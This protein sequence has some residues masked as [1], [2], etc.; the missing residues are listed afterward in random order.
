MSLATSNRDGG[1]TNEAGHLRGVTKGFIGQVLSGLNVSQRG[2]GA[3]MSVDVAIGDALV[4]RSDN[5][6]GHPAWNDAAYNQVIAAADGSN[7]RRDIIVLYIDYG[8]T[9]ST[10]VAN[11]VN[12][13]VKI[14]SVAGTA[15]G[16]PVDPSNVTIQSAVGSGNPFIKLA[17]VRVAAGSTSVTNSVIDDLRLMATAQLQGGWVYDTLFSWVYAS[18]NSFTIAGVDAIS[19]FPVGARLAFYQAGTLKYFT[20]LSAA[21]STNTTITVDGGG[22]YVVANVPIDRPAFS[23]Q[24]S[25]SG[26][27]RSVLNDQLEGYTEIA[28]TTLTATAT[29]LSVLNIPPKRHL[30]LICSAVASGGTLDTNFKFNSDG[31][32][33]YASNGTNNGAAF[34]AISATSLA[35]DSGF[36]SSGQNL[37]IIVEFDNPLTNA[38][39]GQFFSNSADAAGAAT[40][41]RPLWAS[42]KWTG[43]A[44]VSRIDWNNTMGSGSFAIGS[45]IIVLGK[46]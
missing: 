13:V 36:V 35:C 46:D 28:R 42:F 24:N 40:I 41:P 14:T 12:G 11:N 17:R 18:A 20:V 21:F 44:Q 33:N 19:Q 2:A 22:T 16:S 30:R 43:A 15:A 25:P 3:N 1:R 9:P 45:K 32:A 34:S 39:L 6:Y 8:Q 31:G 10:G 7:P 5:T 26:F 38:K 4:Q 27:P 37:N 29:V 23:Y